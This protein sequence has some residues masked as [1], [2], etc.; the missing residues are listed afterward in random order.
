MKDQNHFDKIFWFICFC[1]SF[2]FG[3]VVAITFVPVPKG[4]ERFI[5]LSLGFLLG[6]VVAGCVGYLIG[7]TAI[8]IKKPEQPGTTITDTTTSFKSAASS[9]DI[10][11]ESSNS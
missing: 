11:V 9:E 4:N 5:D 7:G 2:V 3:Y 6:T 1:T 8:P 10:I